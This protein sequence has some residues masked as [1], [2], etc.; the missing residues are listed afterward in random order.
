MYNGFRFAEGYELFKDRVRCIPAAAADLKTTAQERLAWFDGPIAGQPFLCGDELRF[1]DIGL[2]CCMDFAK[3]VGQPFNPELK[4]VSAWFARMDAR[5]SATASLHP[6][7]QQ[8]QM[9][10]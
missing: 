7:W 2:Y 5:P 8:V 4:N 10:V 1:I 9:H 3:D 6:A